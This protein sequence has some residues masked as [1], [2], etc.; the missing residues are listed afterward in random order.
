MELYIYIY[1]LISIPF[2]HSNL[3]VSW[4]VEVERPDNLV[5]VLPLDC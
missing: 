2:G 1:S 3:A 5:G 4:E